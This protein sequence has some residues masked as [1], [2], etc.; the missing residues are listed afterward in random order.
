MNEGAKHEAK[1]GFSIMTF[2]TGMAMGSVIAMLYAPDAGINTRR[3][4]KETIED[5]K[6][7]AFNRAKS[8][9]AKAAEIRESIK[10]KVRGKTRDLARAAT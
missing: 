1:S 8:A 9:E 3:K 4:I 6:A 5:G 10:N 2:I 7:K